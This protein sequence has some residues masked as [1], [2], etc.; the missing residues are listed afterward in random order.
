VDESRQCFS[1]N[2]EL[3]RDLKKSARFKPGESLDT[4]RTPNVVVELAKQ[5][6]EQRSD[7][8]ILSKPQTIADSLQQSGQPDADPFANV[9]GDSEKYRVIHRTASPD[10]RYAIALGF[11]KGKID[12][13]T[14]RDPNS[15]GTYWKEDS[16]YGETDDVD[17]EYGKT[18]NYV[19]D[20]TT[21]RILGTTGCGYFGTRN[22]YNMRE[23]EVVWSPD[24][25]SF[26]QL[27]W[28]K[29][30]YVWCRAGRIIAGP[31]LL[32]TVDLGKHAEKSAKNFFASHKNEKYQGSIAISVS[33][34]TDQG[35]IDL[36]ILGQES[37]GERKG[38]IDF[39]LT[40]RIRLR[41]TPGGLR[42]ET[43]NIRRLPKEE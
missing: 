4:V 30:N 19:V 25:K 7:E 24:S 18:V 43:L 29:W 20:L 40:E 3:I 41:E 28:E 23:C 2:G 33:E 8:A 5:P 14:L 16:A 12:W 39:D 31:K 9:T 42:L 6:K 17:P 27:T 32:G 10:G 38:D 1:G 15:P 13:E 21:R 11:T 34:V 36:D 35:I 26:V 22:R 37:S